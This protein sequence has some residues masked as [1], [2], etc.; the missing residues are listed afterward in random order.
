MSR[1]EIRPEVVKSAVKFL[2]HP[3]VRNQPKEK[4][5]SFLFKKGLSPKEAAQAYRELAKNESKK[6][7]TKISPKDAKEAE[8]DGYFSTIRRAIGNMLSGEEDKVE[9]V[10]TV[11]LEELRKFNGVL[12]ERLLISVEGKIYDVTKRWDLYGPGKKYNVF[13]GKDATYALAMMS[14]ESASMNRFEYEL[15][16]EHKGILGEWIEKYKKSYPVV[17]ELRREEVIK[18]ST[19]TKT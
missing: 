9:E 3:S 12:H 1:T 19:I 6:E 5:L 8:S 2:S 17:G 18:T 10:G 11:T 7:V 13:T 14:A 16:E 4:Q 15:N